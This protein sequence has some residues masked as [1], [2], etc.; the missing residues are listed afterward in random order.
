M[1]LNDELPESF[2]LRICGPYNNPEQDLGDF[3]AVPEHP[4][5]W[6][7]ATYVVKR[8]DFKLLQHGDYEHGYRVCDI[9]KPV[10]VFGRRERNDDD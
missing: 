8:T 2:E 10:L 7:D 5:G 4:G 9:S 3:E 1:R 6:G